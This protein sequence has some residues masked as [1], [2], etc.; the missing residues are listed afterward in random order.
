M[1][2]T[3]SEE[4]LAFLSNHN[5]STVLEL[6]LHINVTKANIRHHLKVLIEHGK[7]IDAGHTTRISRGRPAKRFTINPTHQPDNY[8]EMIDMLFQYFEDHETLINLLNNALY[9]KVD[10]DPHLPLIQRLNRLIKALN[11]RNYQARWESHAQGPEIII[12]NCPYRQLIEK[13]Q[14]FCEIDSRFISKI[15]KQNCVHLHPVIG[16][17]NCKFHLPLTPVGKLIPHSN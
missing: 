13:H 15:T 12:T 2:K 11:E 5:P 8:F 9:K 10:I 16:H 17:Q 3:T 4:I 7:I 1:A 14:E 6:S